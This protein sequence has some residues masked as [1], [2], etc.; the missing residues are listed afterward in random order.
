MTSLS[1]RFYRFV[2]IYL[3][4]SII[5]RDTVKLTLELMCL[6]LGRIVA[7]SLSYVRHPL[8]GVIHYLPQCPQLSALYI[9][10]LKNKEDIDMLL[11]FIPR[12][13]QLT[14]VRYNG[15]FMSDDIDRAVVAAVMSLRQL[16]L[17]RLDEVDLGDYGVDMTDMKRLQTLK[18]GPLIFMS[19][20]CWGR[21]VSSLLTIPQSVSVKIRN[22]RHRRGDGQEDTNLLAS[23]CDTG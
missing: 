2:I 23:D 16:V 12:L 17:V 4:R 5:D 1:L 7:V 13:T 21:F 11:R 19:A 10:R 15:G 9:S 14:S 22:Y 20:G 18:L 6:N 8:N 3:D